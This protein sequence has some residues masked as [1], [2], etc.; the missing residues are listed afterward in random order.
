MNRIQQRKKAKRDSKKLDV[1]PLKGNPTVPLEK[2][3]EVREERQSNQG[4][5]IK[6]RHSRILSEAPKLS[7]IERSKMKNNFKMA[8]ETKKQEEMETG[9]TK[10][11]MEKQALAD[12]E[13]NKAATKTVQ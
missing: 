13:A 12:A 2:D 6:P 3:G 11:E 4:S 10:K 8:L 7:V 9:K 5:G 1:D